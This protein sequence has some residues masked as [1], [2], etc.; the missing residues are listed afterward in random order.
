MISPAG[1]F[2]YE[3]EFT[4][5]S[6]RE[7]DIVLHGTA[8]PSRYDSHRLVGPSPMIR[9]W[10]DRLVLVASDKSNSTVRNT[11]FPIGD[12]VPLAASPGDRLYVVRTGCGGIGLS[13][14]CDKQLVLAIGAVTRVPLG[15]KIQVTKDPKG[16]WLHDDHLSDT[17]L[18]FEVG[19]EQVRLRKRGITEIGNYQIYIESCW[20][21]GV[22]GTDECVS[23]SVANAPLVNLAS[24]RSAILLRNGV[25]KLTRWDCTETFTHF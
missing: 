8:M 23:V 24:V 19:S 12:A 21:Y 9:F 25:L 6:F 14:L 2:E 11:S 18:E 5:D 1:T 20:E 13:L 3:A 22:P 15:N 4:A 7:S 10:N 17:W 16:S